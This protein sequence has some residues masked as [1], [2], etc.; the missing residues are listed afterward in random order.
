MYIAS[1]AELIYRDNVRKH[2]DEICHTTR[3]R[4]YKIPI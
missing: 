3:A 2:I 1:G 4:R